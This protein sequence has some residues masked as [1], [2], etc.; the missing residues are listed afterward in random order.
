LIELYA[1]NPRRPLIPGKN[2]ERLAR[3]GVVGRKNNNFGDVL[4]PE[5]VKRILA[6]RGI[7][8]ESTRTSRLFTIG[9]VLHFASSGDTVWGT[10]RNGKVADTAH[11][12]TTLDVRAVRGPLTATFLRDRGANVPDIYGDPGLLTAKYFPEFQKTSGERKFD[13]TIVPNLNDLGSVAYGENVLD[14]RKPLL[15]CLA[16]IANSRLVVGSSLHGIIVAEAFGVPARLVVSPHEHEFKYRDYYLGTKRDVPDFAA[17]ISEA[18]EMN[19][20]PQLGYDLE[21]L[22]AAFPQDL[23]M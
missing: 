19:G 12:F 13:V 22:E 7:S 1:W 15:E 20:A 17:S 16:R 3:L 23:W 5:L 18:I 9:S 14:P 10:G 4:G 8:S 11:K 2:G 21:A 6:S